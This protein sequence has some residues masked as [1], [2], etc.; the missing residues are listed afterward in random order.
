[1]KSKTVFKVNAAEYHWREVCAQTQNQ[2]ISVSI[3]W[4]G[5]PIPYRA[6]TKSSI[7]G[8]V[9]STQFNSRSIT[10]VQEADQHATEQLYN[11]ILAYSVQ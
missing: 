5:S 11:L 8:E 4:N 1:M 2:L 10:N 9:S 3:I 6:Q 7:K